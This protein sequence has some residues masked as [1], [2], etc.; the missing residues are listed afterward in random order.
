METNVPKSESKKSK[1]KSK[2]DAKCASIRI[3]VGTKKAALAFRDQA[4]NKAFGRSIKLDEVLELAVGKLTSE[5]VHELQEQSLTNE[6]RKELLRQKYIETR[7]PISRDEFTGFMMTD[8]FQEFLKESVV[9]INVAYASAATVY[10]HG[11]TADHY[12]QAFVW[13]NDAVK[14][15]DTSQRIRRGKLDPALILFRRSAVGC[16]CHAES[17]NLRDNFAQQMT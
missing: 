2:S 9:Q 15:G 16:D 17:F 5:H 12:Y 4:N 11:T 13:A 7:G 1:V 3:R 6:D 8:A 14:L 10:Q